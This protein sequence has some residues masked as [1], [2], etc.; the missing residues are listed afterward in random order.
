MVLLHAAVLDGVVLRA[1]VAHALENVHYGDLVIVV[2]VIK[3][4]AESFLFGS[5]TGNEVIDRLAILVEGAILGEV[6]ELDDDVGE[7]DR[8][9]LHEELLDLRPG[10]LELV[11]ACLHARVIFDHVSVD[12]AKLRLAA[13]DLRWPLFAWKTLLESL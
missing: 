10:E 2:L 3:L 1:K 4:E 6:E 9:A 8:V 5:V 12:F 11:S 13:P 7:A